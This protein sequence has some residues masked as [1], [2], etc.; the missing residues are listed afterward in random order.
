MTHLNRVSLTLLA[1]WYFGEWVLAPPA[2]QN[3]ILGNRKEGRPTLMSPTPLYYFFVSCSGEK[4]ILGWRSLLLS[5]S[6]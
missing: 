5:I 4:D 1:I 6:Q 2:F 3:V